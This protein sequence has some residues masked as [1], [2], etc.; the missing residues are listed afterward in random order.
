VY[1]HRAMCTY[2]LQ[3]PCSLLRSLYRKPNTVRGHAREVLMGEKMTGRNGPPSAV[4]T[5]GL[6]AALVPLVAVLATLRLD[7][8]S[9]VDA[10]WDGDSSDDSAASLLLAAAEPRI[11]RLCMVSPRTLV[12][13]RSSRRRRFSSRIICSSISFANASGGALLAASA[14]RKPSSTNSQL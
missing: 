11:V 4:E 5:D 13:F 1:K 6:D 2:F 12:R 10:E 8:D 14:H 9:T 7:G 3:S